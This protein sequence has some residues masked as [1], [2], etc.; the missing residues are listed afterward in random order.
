MPRQ[1][2][3]PEYVCHGAENA[4]TYMKRTFTNHAEDAHA[5]SSS[6]M[7]TVLSTSLTSGHAQTCFAQVSPPPVLPSVFFFF[8]PGG[9]EEG[10]GQVGVGKKRKRMFHASSPATT[11][12]H[13]AWHNTEN[14]LE[15]K[16]YICR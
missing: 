3:V 1:E 13:R 7:S 6:I 15:G 9:G 14:T 8:L 12:S 5:V 10:G 11:A 2:G 4:Q 16:M